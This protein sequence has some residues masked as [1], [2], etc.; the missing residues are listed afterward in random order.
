MAQTTQTARVK[1]IAATELTVYNLSMPLANTEY[2][3]VLNNSTKKLS[4]KV[5]DNLAKL[6]LSIVS[7]GTLIEW[8]TI[9]QGCNWSNDNLDLSSTTIYLSSNNASVVAEIEE[10]T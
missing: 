10:W 3:Q 1:P 8:V 4:I 9:P 6:K 2:S 5:R 7:G